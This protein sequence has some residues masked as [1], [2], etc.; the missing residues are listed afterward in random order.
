MQLTSGHVVRGEPVCVCAEDPLGG[1]SG[2]LEPDLLRALG[3]T[4]A[5][6]SWGLGGAGSRPLMW[7]ELR[8]FFRAPITPSA[9]ASM[10]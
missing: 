2:S 4:G 7:G 10:V 3:R 1:G 5:S 8:V 6:G 9:S